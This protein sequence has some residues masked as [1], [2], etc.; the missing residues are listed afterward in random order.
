[1]RWTRP[2]ALIAVAAPLALGAV[3]MSAIPG[4]A[5]ACSRPPPPP[6]RVLAQDGGPDVWIGRVTSITPNLNPLR[7]E[8]LEV[9]QS[10]A[11]IEQVETVLGQPPARYEYV[12]AT[13]SKAIDGSDYYWCGPWMNVEVG[14]AILLIDNPAGVY[15]YRLG[16]PDE[17]ARLQS[18]SYP[19]ELMSRLESYQ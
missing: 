16:Q 3:L 4:V 19:S 1:M 10:T 6:W 17:I 11:T 8:R 12:G 13:S 7:N 18:Y 14:E 5:N 9:N 2:H 15:I